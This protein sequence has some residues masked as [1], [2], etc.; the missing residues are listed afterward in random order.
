MQPSQQKRAPARA[1]ESPSPPPSIPSAYRTARQKH[2][3]D[4]DRA[5]TPDGTLEHILPGLPAAPLTLGSLADL[6][7]V[8]NPLIIPQ[9]LSNELDYSAAAL[10]YIWRHSLHYR[11]RDSR[12]LR[13]LPSRLA[14]AYHK[15]KLIRGTIRSGFTTQQ[16]LDCCAAHLTRAFEEAPETLASPRSDAAHLNFP[17]ISTLV[18]YLDELMSAYHLTLSDAR[19]ITLSQANQLLKAMALRHARQSPH[20]KPPRFLE[21]KSLRKAAAADLANLNRNN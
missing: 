6:S 21:P 7:A 20:L 14:A 10:T 16:L 11:T 2:Q 8:G 15:R 4:R 9:S 1:P 12:A 3:R 13:G 17:P 18:F 5:F 19:N